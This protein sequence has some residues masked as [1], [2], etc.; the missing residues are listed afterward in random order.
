MKFFVGLNRNKE[1]ATPCVRF[2]TLGFA[3]LTALVVL[4]P[5]CSDKSSDEEDASVSDGTLP[6]DGDLPTD[7][8]LPTDGE[9]VD[10]STPGDCGEINTFEHGQTPL[11]EIHVA[12]GGSDTSGDGSEAN[13]FATISRAAGE[14]DPGTAIRVH[15]G[16]YEGG[17]YLADLAGTAEA[18]IWI[19]GVAGE[20]RP[21]IQGGGQALHLVRPRYVIVHDLEV[22]GQTANGI[23]ADDGGDYAN[24]LAAHHVVF[25]NLLIHTVGSGGNQDCLKLSGLNHFYVLDSEFHHC[26]GGSAGSAVDC[27]GCHHGL[28]AGNHMHSLHE[29]GNAVQTKGGSEDIEIRANLIIDG[30]Q[31][32]LL[33]GGSTGFAYFRP[34]LSTDE[35]NVEARNIRALSNI[36]VGGVAAVA[37]VGC[38][39]CIAANNTIVNPTRWILR[40]LQE[41]TSEGDY[42]FAPCRDG[43]FVNNIVYFDRSALST[44]INVGP[45]TQ[46]ESFQFSHNLWYA[47]DDPSLSQP[48]NLPAAETAGIYEQDPGLGDDHQ[49]TPG[50][51]A[52]GAGAPVAEVFGDFF[53]NCYADPPSIGAHEV[54]PPSP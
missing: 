35:E 51:P 39:D 50:S 5:A 7:G 6:T 45:N 10:G 16:A 28:I 32:G 21:V 14:A 9:A 19:G 1:V 53:G 27:V 12:Q 49:I 30:G 29:G 3:C 33:M 38:V 18:P 31:R 44:W 23:N 42:L 47:H 24:N 11:S 52:A 8:T 37:F 22:T 41:T 2:L 20:E 25:R 17:A 40:I 26:G 4:G 13:P 54:A 43:R 48:T 15:A 34:P 46:A 36:F